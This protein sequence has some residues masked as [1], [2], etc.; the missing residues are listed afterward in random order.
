M[1]RKT[2]AFAF[3]LAL[4]AAGGLH[5]QTGARNGEWRHYGGDAGHTR[6]SPLDQINASNFN[7]LAIA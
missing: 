7:D 1:L 6:Y 3:A 2:L 4:A 5:G